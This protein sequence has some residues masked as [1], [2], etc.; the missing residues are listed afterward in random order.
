MR[1]TKFRRYDINVLYIDYVAQ[2]TH[3]IAHNYIS[4]IL[5]ILWKHTIISET[6]DLYYKIIYISFLAVF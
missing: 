3:F 4:D 6:S 5:Y 2:T 1:R